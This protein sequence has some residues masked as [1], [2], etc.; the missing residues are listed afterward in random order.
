MLVYP[1]LQEIKSKNSS[2]TKEMKNDISILVTKTD[3]LADTPL[4]DIFENSSVVYAINMYLEMVEIKWVTDIKVT[5]FHAP[6][7]AVCRP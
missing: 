2:F 3:H 5:F 1:H 7:R 6:A 4:S